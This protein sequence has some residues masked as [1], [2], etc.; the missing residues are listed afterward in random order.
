MSTDSPPSGYLWSAF[1]LDANIVLSIRI[2]TWNV[3]IVLGNKMLD[4]NLNGEKLKKDKQPKWKTKKKG[5]LGGR[6]QHLKQ[7][8]SLL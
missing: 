1:D 6:T 5:Y 3:L 8:I 2:L 4:E 7:Y